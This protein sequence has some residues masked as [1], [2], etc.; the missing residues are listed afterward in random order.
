M[1]PGSNLEAD[2]NA[3]LGANPAAVGSDAISH[4]FQIKADESLILL[5]GCGIAAKPF[6]V[7]VDVSGQNGKDPSPAVRQIRP[8]P[9][10]FRL[11][12]V[13]QNRWLEPLSPSG[14]N[15]VQP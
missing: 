10:V 12:I 3:G 14:G 1:A 2:N 11:V 6:R 13:H 15:H 8:D 7:A 4:A 5:P 9:V